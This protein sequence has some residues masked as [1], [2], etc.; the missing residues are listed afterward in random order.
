MK[1]DFH[2]RFRENLRVKLPWVTRLAA[3]FE[4]HVTTDKFD[5]GQLNFERY[6]HII[7][8][9]IILA[10]TLI[11]LIIKFKKICGQNLTQS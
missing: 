3:I 8:A 7:C 5:S 4:R 2:V 9:H 10:R 11:N 6:L 1:G